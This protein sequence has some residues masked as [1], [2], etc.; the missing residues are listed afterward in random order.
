MVNATG[1]FQ[2]SS[3]GLNVTV[4]GGITIP[5]TQTLTVGTIG[6]N[7]SGSGTL[8]SGANL[9]GVYDEMVNSSSNILQQVL[10]DLDSSITSAG[11]SP[12]T[13]DTDATYGDYIRPTTLTD[14]FVLGGGGT[15]DTS[16]LF[17]NSS[18]SELSIGT[19]ESSNGSITLLFRRKCGK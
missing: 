8:T 13:V 17:F 19:N 11:V 12:F 16:N 18:T 6:L 14:D 5:D 4:A 10:K 2:I 3:T 9:V 1:I 15:P 7:A